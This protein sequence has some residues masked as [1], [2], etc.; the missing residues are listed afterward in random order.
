MSG[1]ALVAELK[2]GASRWFGIKASQRA[3]RNAEAAASPRRARRRPGDKG[4]IRNGGVCVRKISTQRRRF[5]QVAR[6]LWS[7][8]KEVG[9]IGYEFQ[10]RI[11]S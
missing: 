9:M 2:K 1:T 5:F 11:K 7:V 10:F 3:Q 4:V 8:K 6:H